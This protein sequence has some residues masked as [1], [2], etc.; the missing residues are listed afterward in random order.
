MKV[1]VI[2]DSLQVQK[3]FGAMLSVLPDVELVGCARDALGAISLIDATHPDVV[4]LDVNLLDDD[5]GIDV[6]HYVRRQHG[7]AIVVALSNFVSERLR[8]TY[9]EAG[10]SAYFDKSTEFTQ[11]RD[12]IAQLGAARN[13]ASS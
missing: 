10:A 2:D 1:V 4:V 8:Q 6:L 7:K 13:G 11:A 9:L 3:S 5:K 12:W